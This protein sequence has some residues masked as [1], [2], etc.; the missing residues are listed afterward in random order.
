MHPAPWFGGC[1]RPPVTVASVFSFVVPAVLPASLTVSLQHTCMHS[2]AR[3]YMHARFVQFAPYARAAYMLP[4]PLQ[5]ASMPG[6]DTCMPYPYRAWW[7]RSDCACTDLTAS[8]VVRCVACPSHCYIG[9]G[10]LR[11]RC[12]DQSF[13][14]PSS[15]PIPRR[16][17]TPRHTPVPAPCESLTVPMRHLNCPHSSPGASL[18]RSG[19][20]AAHPCAAATRAAMARSTAR[21]PGPMPMALTCMTACAR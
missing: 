2:A 16:Y 17:T 1:P 9:R 6:F 7:W 14:M 11:G 10:V 20:A 21:S 19:L 4:A 13:D 18:Q 3:A 12:S 15:Q 8:S 5:S